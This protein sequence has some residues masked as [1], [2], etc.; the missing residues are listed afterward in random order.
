[1]GD[2]ESA[3][4]R[5][6]SVH[7]QV[8]KT[9]QIQMSGDSGNISTERLNSVNDTL[10][11]EE[12]I[13]R[14]Q[15]SFAEKASKYNEWLQACYV[16]VEER[17]PELDGVG[18]VMTEV[19]G[20]TLTDVKSI[21]PFKAK[22]E[23]N[24]KSLMD[25]SNAALDELEDL[26]ERLKKLDIMPEDDNRF[27]F[28]SIAMLEDL[29]E[30]FC[31]AIGRRAEAFDEES[32]QVTAA[33]DIVTKF[34]DKVAEYEQMSDEI[35]Y[36]VTSATGELR[37]VL[38]EVRGVYQEGKE[39]TKRFDEIESLSADCRECGVV[40]TNMVVLRVKN[41][42]PT[43]YLAL[44]AMCEKYIHQLDNE[45]KLKDEYNK[46]AAELSDWFQKTT[47]RFSPPALPNNLEKCEELVKELRRYRSDEKPQK[48]RDLRVAL[49]YM[50]VI[51]KTLQYQGRDGFSPLE[52]V[53]LADQYAT[54]C[55]VVAAYTDRLF[56]E[57]TRLQ[58][59]GNKVQEFTTMAVELLE[60]LKEKQ[61][62]LNSA[63]TAA[64]KTK[65][66]ARSAK[67][68]MQSFA[69]EYEERMADLEE[70][71]KVG[72]EIVEHN[73]EKLD[74]LATMYDKLCIGFQEA[75]L[76]PDAPRRPPLPKPREAILPPS[77]TAQAAA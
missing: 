6:L 27:T 5:R 32:R 40:G 49:D 9:Y 76:N 19:G 54:V 74:R 30:E 71:E 62:F 57:V 8:E 2:R 43:G 50:G 44:K 14:L 68:M 48:E 42:T 33:H 1:M 24:D 28:F 53:T 16:G 56:K 63:Y 17:F 72:L 45:L 3:R 64:P 34:M 73:Y 22:L 31:S 66:A 25:A 60:W 75:S 46:R 12:D 55:D 70:A 10:R 67:A 38:D 7:S 59:V 65:S 29:H 23:E 39:L 35:N 15:E 61:E 26:T 11:K 47:Q 69:V 36:K 13:E 4:T 20:V 58:Y 77:D 52:N 37:H 18:L 51:E 21:K 41:A